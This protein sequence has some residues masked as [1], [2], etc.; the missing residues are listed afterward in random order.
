MVQLYECIVGVELAG[1]FS[2]GSS[3]EQCR[4][5]YSKIR[6]LKATA[7]KECFSSRIKWLHI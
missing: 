3:V 5:T 6:K 2:E 4:P 1:P 7:G